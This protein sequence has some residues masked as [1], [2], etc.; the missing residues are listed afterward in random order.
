MVID[1]NNLN[2]AGSGRNRSAT[3]AA[4]SKTQT[5]AA[6]NAVAS[7]SDGALPNSK[8]NVVLS[9]E[10]QSLSRLQAKINELPDVNVERVAA[11]KLAIAE[12]RFAFNSERIAENMLKQDELLR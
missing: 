4:F 9:P 5:P 10:A 1:T 7:P 12:G 8:N 6:E 3:N 11:I 2:P